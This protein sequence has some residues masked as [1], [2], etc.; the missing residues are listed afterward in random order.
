MSTQP[1]LRR[2]IAGSQRFRIVTGAV[3]SAVLGVSL[4]VSTAPT[5]EALSPSGHHGTET[6]ADAITKVSTVAFVDV[7]GPKVKAIVVKYDRALRAGAATTKTYDVFSYA[8]LPIVYDVASSNGGPTTGPEAN[9]PYTAYPTFTYQN[10]TPG[11]ATKV[12]VSSTPKIDPR[13]KGDARGHYVIIELNTD[14]QLTSTVKAWR[15]GVAGGVEQKVQVTL[16]DGTRVTPSDDV[17][18]NYAPSYVYDIS[19]FGDSHSATY[20]EVFDDSLYTLKD[21]AGYKIYTDDVEPA[22]TGTAENGKTVNYPDATVLKKVA[23]NAFQASNAFSEYDGKAHHVSLKYSLY[24][25]RN[26]SPR[27]K[28]MLVLHIED[29]GGLGDDPMISLTEAQAAANYASP[30]VQRFAKSQGYGGLIVAIPQIPNSGQSVADNLTG[31]EYLPAT[32]QLMD[33]LTRRYNI[34]KN[35]IYGSGQSMG[36]MQ[37]LDMAAQR[38]NYFAGIW[39]IGSQWGSNYDKAALYHGSSYFTYPTDGKMITNSD[40]QNW[41]YAVSDDNILATNMTGDPTATGYWNET[42]ELYTDL[43]GVSIPYAKWDPTTTSVRSQNAQLKSLLS[44]PN[45]LGIYWSALSGGDHRSTWIY[46]HRLSTAYYWLLKQT[47]ST[48]DARGKLDLGTPYP[49]GTEGYT[50]KSLSNVPPPA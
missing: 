2:D 43:A 45:K 46:A 40:W 3:V 15:S 16:A 4:I 31:N 34:D 23:G 19:P 1:T 18:S 24:V 36:G 10:G 5:S 13:G 30:Q 44:M 42:Q 6:A 32:W 35:R 14:Y 41:Y 17:E 28:Y 37:I 26:Y 27:K 20:S 7:D 48:E 9:Q 12:Y 29:G 21:L 11:A 38:D 25:P 39:S 49:N 22:H 47:K 33:R 50:S 8:N